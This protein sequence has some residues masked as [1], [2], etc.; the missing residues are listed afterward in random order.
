MTGLI[1]NNLPLLKDTSEKNRLKSL[2]VFGG[3]TREDFSEIS[4]VDF[5]YKFKK[6]IAIEEYAENYFNFLFE[7]EILLQRKIDLIA[8]DKLKNP[9]FIKQIEAEKQNIYE[10]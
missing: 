1:K 5:L 10:A 6:D 7:L 4:D 2:A 3:A 8:V 9:F